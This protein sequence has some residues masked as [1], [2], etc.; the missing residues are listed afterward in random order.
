M[1][2][3]GFKPEDYEGDDSFEPVP[4]GWYQAMIVDSEEKETKAGTGSYLQL[5][6]E[7]VGPTHA[8]RKLWDRLNLN[9]PNSTA[10]EIAQRTLAGICRAVGVHAP[11]QSEDLHDKLLCVRVKHREYQGETREEVSGYKPVKGASSPKPK[12]DGKAPPPWQRK[13]G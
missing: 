7:I 11:K 10:V 8:G 3:N 13:A 6:L 4:A 12:G 9:N 5:T 2:L 1:D